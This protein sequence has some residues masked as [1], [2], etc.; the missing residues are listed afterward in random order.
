[1][2]SMLS[3]PGE[4]V[5]ITRPPSRT[6]AITRLQAFAILLVSLVCSPL[7]SVAQTAQAPLTTSVSEPTF[8]AIDTDTSGTKWLYVSNHGDIGTSATLPNN[9]GQILKFN[10]TSG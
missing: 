2:H 6:R 4:T 1:M 9:G 5:P 10:L 3:A 8:V 7:T